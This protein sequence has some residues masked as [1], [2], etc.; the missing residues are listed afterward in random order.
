MK[1]FELK[2]EVKPLVAA[3]YLINFVRFLIYK[4]SPVMIKYLLKLGLLFLVITLISCEKDPVNEP[5]EIGPTHTSLIYIV[6]D[7]NL[8]SYPQGDLKEMIA[9]YKEVE[10]KDNNTL[11]VYLDDYSTPRLLRITNENGEVV[12]KT[13]KEFPEQNSLEVNVMAHTI[14]EALN[15]FKADSYGL[16]LWSHGDGWLPGTEQKKTPA[17]RSFGEDGND[18]KSHTSTYMDILDLKNV[19]ITTPGF[20]YL[21][22]DACNMQGIEVAYEL[23]EVT[24]YMIGSPVEVSAYGAPYQDMVPALFSESNKAENI[25]RAFFNQY[26]LNFDYQEFEETKSGLTKSSVT[27]EIN[28]AVYKYGAA[29]S[30]ISCK[31]LD[32]LALATNT[33]LTDFGENGT[34]IPTSEIFSYDSNF[35]NFYY[36][37]KGLISNISGTNTAAWQT[38]EAAYQKAVPLFLTTPATYSSFVHNGFGG[39]LSMS[40][41]NGVSTFIPLNENFRAA[42]RWRNFSEDDEFLNGEYHYYRDYYSKF[43]WYRAAG[44]KQVKE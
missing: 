5:V 17:T 10:N 37:L 21:V 12:A 35:Y 3:P 14:N 22:F 4:E 23:R 28:T 2:S 9:G 7:N 15:L 40:Q 25:A 39:N 29:V 42:Y 38:W 18:G 16:V 26:V 44:W 19:L 27:E 1:R 13:I 20:E 34:S 6:A 41:A 30:V 36:D 24:D 31:D 33:I 43:E 8:N 11:L 32:E